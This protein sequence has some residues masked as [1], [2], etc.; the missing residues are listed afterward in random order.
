MTNKNYQFFEC[1]VVFDLGN[2]RYDSVCVD[3][4]SVF[5]IEHTWAR[6][7]LVKSFNLIGGKYLGS[8]HFESFSIAPC[9]RLGTLA[10]VD[11]AEYSE[12]RKETFN[13]IVELYRKHPAVE[14]MMLMDDDITEH[15]QN[16]PKTHKNK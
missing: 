12:Q 9:C 7:F 4:E 11:K 1:P 15:Y 10:I 8:H 2:E 14:V 5:G 16:Y 13:K 3:V 6:P